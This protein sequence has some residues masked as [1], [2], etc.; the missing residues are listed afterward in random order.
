[1][2]KNERLKGRFCELL[3]LFLVLFAVAAVCVGDKIEVA[4]TDVIVLEDE[5]GVAIVAVVVVVELGIGTI[6]IVA[7]VVRRDAKLSGTAPRVET[8]EPLSSPFL[9]APDIKIADKFEAEA[10]TSVSALF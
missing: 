1:M 2:S 4:G 9:L 8:L 10:K 6:E 5:E 7:D 3:S